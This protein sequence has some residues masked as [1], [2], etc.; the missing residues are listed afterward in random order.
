MI[1][2]EPLGS[3]S[4][5]KNYSYSICTTLAQ[6]TPRKT[7]AFVLRWDLALVPVMLE[8]AVG[9]SSDGAQL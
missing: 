3:S 9:A 5:V 2:S 8:V 1:K 7:E 6:K 4:T